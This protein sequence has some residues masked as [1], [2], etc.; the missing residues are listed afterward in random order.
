MRL[1]LISDF[2]KCQDAKVIEEMFD[3]GMERFHIRE[4]D[5]EKV[6][7]FVQ[8]IDVKYRN[9]LS[10]HGNEASFNVDSHG[11]FEEAKSASCH[12]ILEVNQSKKEYV[13]LSPVFDSISKPGYLSNF[14]LNE[15]EVQ[16]K[17]VPTRVYALGGVSDENIR[18]LKNVGFAGA[19]VKGFIWDRGS[20]PVKQFELLWNKCK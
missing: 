8:N 6:L 18:L 16:L 4:K 1:I 13:F 5:H 20:S 10:Y 11:D 9:K 2:N 19:A 17:S 3:L 14:S 15:L 12:T 7:R